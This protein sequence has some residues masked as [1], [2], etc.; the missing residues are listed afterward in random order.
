MAGVAAVL[1][2]PS[3]LSE[4]QKA[5]AT[6][7]EILQPA[8]AKGGHAPTPRMRAGPQGKLAN[9]RNRESQGED[10]GPGAG[11][12]HH[13]VPG[14]PAEDNQPS[15][16]HRDLP[17]GGAQQTRASG[18]VEVGQLRRI[19]E[20]ASEGRPPVQGR[21]RGASGASP[22]WFG[23]QG[24]E[25]HPGQRHLREKH[26]LQRGLAPGRRP[27]PEEPALP[28]G[29]NPFIRA[30]PG[31]SAAPSVG[32]A[33]R[34]SAMG[35]GRTPGVPRPSP[36]RDE[37]GRV[38]AEEAEFGAE[39]GIVLAPRIVQTP[40]LP[41]RPSGISMMNG[42]TEE[43]FQNRRVTQA[44]NAMRGAMDYDANLK[45]M[46]IH[47]QKPVGNGIRMMNG[48]SDESFAMRR[49][50]QEGTG[51][52]DL[53]EFPYPGKDTLKGN[54]P[55]ERFVGDGIRRMNGETDES[56]AMRKMQQQ[57]PEVGA[58]MSYEIVQH[59]KVS[60]SQSSRLKGELQ[61][62]WRD[63][64]RKQA[65]VK[66]RKAADA[67]EREGRARH[68]EEW[69]RALHQGA[70]PRVDAPRDHD[71]ILRDARAAE[72]MNFMRHNVNRVVQPEGSY[73]PRHHVKDPLPQLHSGYQSAATTEAPINHIRLNKH[74]EV[75]P[76]VPKAQPP[77]VR[78]TPDHKNRG[79]VPGYLHRREQ[80]LEREAQLLRSLHDG[81]TQVPLPH[82][83]PQGARILSEGERRQVLADLRKRQEQLEVHLA[84]KTPLTRPNQN[85]KPV[86]QNRERHIRKML[87]DVDQQL[88]RFSQRLVYVDEDWE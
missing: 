31:P 23:H 87:R 44:G 53:V 34:Q 55:R 10:E 83:V 71:R 1:G 21:S 59:P 64:Q 79:K 58:C 32:R 70:T 36:F 11:R 35:G 17:P 65:E 13:H 57:S 37:V 82:G 4:S 46:Q 80:E 69:Q 22:K 15:H 30:T 3:F 88:D 2:G 25:E 12:G 47:S 16:R 77:K 6:L 20:L 51:A 43:A 19:Q 84:T 39:A 28:P 14:R 8:W 41:D 66:E 74:V 5:Q 45:H 54:G 52:K 86:D 75:Q 49:R 60:V 48:E 81:D 26:A 61:A 7:E 62:N 68:L 18:A 38:A 67:A 42:E 29:R 72:P 63:I 50:M 9:L 85:A 73:A 33:S 24:R 56:F 27:G 78:P 76:R 40:E